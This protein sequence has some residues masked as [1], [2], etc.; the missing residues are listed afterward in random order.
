MTKKNFS[1]HVDEIMAAHNGD[2]TMRNKNPHWQSQ[3]DQLKQLFQKSESISEQM[4]KETEIYK[5]EL[6]ER[7]RLGLTGDAAIQH[8][9][10]FMHQHNMD[11]L[12]V[13]E[14]G[15]TAEEFKEIIQRLGE[16]AAHVND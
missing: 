16:I 15:C 13:S 3:Y 6:E 9:N 2:E 14:S 4:H 5:Q 12:T 7:L 8:Y 11:Y 10:D 1:N